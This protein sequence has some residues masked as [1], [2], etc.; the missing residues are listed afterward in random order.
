MSD[1]KKEGRY[2]PVLTFSLLLDSRNSMS[3]AVEVSKLDTKEFI[4]HMDH[5]M[6]DFDY[7]HD[8]ANL[9]Q[10]CNNL[11]DDLENPS[12]EN[13]SLSVKIKEIGHQT[14]NDTMKLVNNF[15]YY[16]SP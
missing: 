5:Y 14:L 2:I 16:W 6:P 11:I 15:I 10:Y 9:I 13:K 8:I 12:K 7:T 1:I 3:P 4:E